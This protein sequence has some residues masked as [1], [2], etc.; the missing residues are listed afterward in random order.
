MSEQRPVHELRIGRI[1]AAVWENDGDGSPW[2]AVT[3]RRV[4]R[5]DD[6]WRT[7]TSFREIDLPV[8][9]EL[10]CAAHRWIR[11]RVG[12]AGPSG[13]GGSEAERGEDQEEPAD[14]AA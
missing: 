13:P 8:L 10:A 14:R 9:A 4:Y 3:F 6:A 1:R 5:S 12:I 11:T 2:H 7:S